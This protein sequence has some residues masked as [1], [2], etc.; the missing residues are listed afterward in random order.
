MDIKKRLAP[1]ERFLPMDK[2]LPKVETPAT[3]SPEPATD[4]LPSIT[5]AADG[6]VLVGLLMVTERYLCDIRI[7]GAEPRLDFDFV[8]KNS[9]IDYR[10][11]LWTQDLKVGEVVKGSYEL[12]QVVLRHN[13]E[14]LYTQLA[15]A[16]DARSA[17]LERVLR[18]IPI[19]VLDLERR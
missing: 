7:A 3:M 6:P 11:V 19:S 15:Y 8:A 14:N 17:W 18:A 13:G 1:L 9:I 16:G 12:A 2:L 5:L 10:F 4:F